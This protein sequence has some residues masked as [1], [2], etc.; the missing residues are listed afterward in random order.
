[1]SEALSG[2]DL[3][4]AVPKFCLA[5]EQFRRTPEGRIR[6]SQDF[7]NHFCPHDDKSC[8][9]RIFKYIPQ[10]TRGPILAAWGIRGLKSAL[11]DTDDRVQTVLHESLTA[12]DLDHASFEDGLTPDIV[13]KWA[14]LADFWSFWRAG[15]LT[16]AAIRKALE[17]AFE[18]QLFD[19]PWFLDTIESSSGRLRGTDVLAEGLSKAELTAW[20]RR[21]HET[22]DGSPKGVL[23]ALGW[24]TAVTKTNDSVLIGILDSVATKIGLKA[25]PEPVAARVSTPGIVAPPPA[26]ALA[27]GESIAQSMD[28]GE[29]RASLGP[30]ISEDFLSDDDLEPT[31]GVNVLPPVDIGMFTKKSDSTPP[32]AKGDGA[33]SGRGKS[34]QH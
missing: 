11:R 18:L 17:S 13:I 31:T 16:K 34:R 19:A 27:E 33:P 15:K 5:L 30:A 28:T 8:T 7:L 32:P 4:Q 14:P 6:S 12:G 25:A 10:A 22:R 3:D 26:T 1:V 9:D 24:E 29:V 21:I 23:S 20:L 2:N